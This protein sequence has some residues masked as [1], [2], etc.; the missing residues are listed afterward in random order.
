VQQFIQEPSKDSHP[1]NIE[2]LSWLTDY[3]PRPFRFDTF[4]RPSDVPPSPETH[5]PPRTPDNT[6][7]PTKKNWKELI[8][9]YKKE[10]ALILAAF[11]L[12]AILLMKIFP[13]KQCMY[14]AGDHYEAIDCNKQ[15][16]GVQS[17]ALDTMKLYHFKK[18]TKPDTMTTYSLGKTWYL[19]TD[20]AKPDCFTAD[21]THP[22]Y[23]KR[24]LRPLTLTILRKYFGATQQDSIP[25]R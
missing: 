10:S 8:K 4:K 21:G 22:L 2:L 1:R 11:G 19:K 12:A 6:T 17:I 23:P 9:K 3:Q 16:F 13:G 5:Q 14:W 20:G 24:D 25:N 15:I 18:I 7:V